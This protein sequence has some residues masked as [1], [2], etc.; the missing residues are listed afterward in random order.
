MLALAVLFVCVGIVVGVAITA[1]EV[2]CE[3]IYAFLK[4][5]R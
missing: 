2:A 4:V 5:R 3:V 1:I